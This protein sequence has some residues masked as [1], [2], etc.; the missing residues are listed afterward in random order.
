MPF[1]PFQDAQASL[2]GLQG[3][4]NRLVERVWHAGLST[5]PFDGQS[6]GPAVDLYEYQDHYTMFA[7]IPGVDAEGVE[8]THVGNAL[9]I[10]GERRNPVGEGEDIRPVR[11]E[12]RFGAFCRTVNLPGDID[13]DRLSARCADGVLEITIPKSPSSMP[14]AVRVDVQEG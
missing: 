8:V 12:R 6:W 10:R 9:T 13:A 1:T 4:I 5:K 2:G 14:K 11:N 3:E 7:E